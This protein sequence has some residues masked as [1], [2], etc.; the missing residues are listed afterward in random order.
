MGCKLGGHPIEK[1]SHHQYHWFS[2]H[3][4]GWMIKMIY[5]IAQVESQKG[6]TF[7][8]YEWG[9]LKRRTCANI[10]PGRSFFNNQYARQSASV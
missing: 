4:K 5:A 6:P 9:K 8:A 2:F 1:K 10:W 3:I 7:V